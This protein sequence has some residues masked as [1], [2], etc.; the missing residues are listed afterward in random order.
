MDTNKKILL[1]E[2]DTLLRKAIAHFLTGH[3]FTVIQAADGHEAEDA[4]KT[5]TFD[6]IITDLNM[7]FKGGMEIIQLVHSEMKLSTPIIVLTVSGVEKVE[8]E[9]LA[10]GASEFIAKPFS[11]AILKARIDKLLK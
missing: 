11:L 10:S 3:N 1:A 6:L 4:V 5:A 8:L 2:D 7:P 9:S